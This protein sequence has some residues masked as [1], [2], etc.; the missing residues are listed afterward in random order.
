M[1]KRSGVID[2]EEE[3]AKLSLAEL[4]REIDRCRTRLR[5]ARSS[6]L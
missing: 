2:T 6:R 1:G 4:D 3:L 5:I